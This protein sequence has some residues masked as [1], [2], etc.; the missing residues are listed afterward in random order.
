[1]T[2]RT[3]H[4]IFILFA[5]VLADMFGAWAIYHRALVEGP[6][7]VLIGILSLLGGLALCWYAFAFVRKMDREGVV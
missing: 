2:L 6:Q 5:I 4:L 3:I 1:M 7:L